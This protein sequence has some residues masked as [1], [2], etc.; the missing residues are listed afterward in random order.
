MFTLETDVPNGQCRRNIDTSQIAD[1]ILKKSLD[2]AKRIVAG[3]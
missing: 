1:E 2:E 3:S